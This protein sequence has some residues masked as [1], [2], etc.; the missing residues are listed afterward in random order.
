M[1]RFL[2][3]FLVLFLSGCVTSSALYPWPKDPSP[4]GRK[5]FMKAHPNMAALVKD[6]IMKDYLRPGVS[7]ETIKAKWGEPCWFY[8]DFSLQGRMDHWVFECEKHW[9]NRSH[10]YFTNGKVYAWGDS[11]SQEAEVQRQK[12]NNE[13]GP[14]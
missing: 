9:K 12:A 5:A 1:K 14:E 3:A 13:R 6:G 2:F 10:V 7:K 11:W 8:T 4:K